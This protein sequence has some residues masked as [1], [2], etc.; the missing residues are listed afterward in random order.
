MR[1]DRHVRRPVLRLWPPSRYWRRSD[2]RTT[3][4]GAPALSVAVDCNA[5]RSAGPGLAGF[6]PKYSAP[7]RARVHG[8]RWRGSPYRHLV[9]SS[10]GQYV[11]R[12]STSSTDI[13][14]HTASHLTCPCAKRTEACPR[15]TANA[16]THTEPTKRS[17]SIGGKYYRPEAEAQPLTEL[18][19]IGPI[20]TSS[21]PLTLKIDQRLRPLPDG[22]RHSKR[23]NWVR[24]GCPFHAAARLRPE[25]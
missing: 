7:A 15:Q 4:K 6:R 19:D 11:V 16:V 17:G 10:L 25:L 5:N 9:Q 23:H 20:R 18:L 21:R 24:F 2:P 14:M 12:F 1:I 13:T 3:V 22:H 8:Y